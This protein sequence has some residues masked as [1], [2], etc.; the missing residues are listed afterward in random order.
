MIRKVLY[1]HYQRSERD[2][3]YVH[4]KEFEAAFQTLCD[5][6]GIAF[7]VFSPPLVKHS[8]DGIPG[9]W[10]RLKSALARLYLRDI[11]ILLLQVRNYY[12]ELAILRREKPD[13][14]LTRYNHGNASLAIL[15]ACR[16]LK[17]PVV[18]ELNSPNRDSDQGARYLRLPGLV[19]LFSARHAL[20]LANGLFAVSDEISAPLR[21]QATAGQPVVTIPNG[22][23]IKRFDPSLSPLPVR[24]KLGIPEDRVV[25]GFVGSF[26]PWHGLD[27]L[28]DAFSVLLKEGLPVHLLLVGQTN[29]MWQA[30]LDRLNTPELV[31]HVSLAGFVPPDEIPPYL[32]AMDIT[33]LPNQAGYCS[34]LKLFEY[35]AMARPPVSVDT[36]PVAATMVDGKEGLLFPAGDVNALIDRMRDLTT[37]RERRLALGAAARVRMEK[38]FT[39][40]HNAERIFAL[41]DE[42][43]RKAHERI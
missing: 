18:I 33:T 19:E 21:K 39:W 41:L 5:E 13:V 6:K 29:P 42:S 40:T 10:A 4:T 8:G 12:K 34:P 2:G 9:T 28:I 24:N 37:H 36:A 1:F 27:F 30:Q 25:F 38:D 31:R 16:R 17:I 35:M 15:W 22:V 32:A 11:K 26:A 23:D 20:S 3:S 14:V 43:Y 7:K